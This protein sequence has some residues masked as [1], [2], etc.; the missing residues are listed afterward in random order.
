MFQSSFFGRGLTAR[1]LA[2][3]MLASAVAVPV[4][5]AGTISGE[6]ADASGTR[7]L[8]GAEVSLVELSQSAEVGQDGSY[9]FVNVPAGTYTLRVRY[10]GAE[11]QTRV[12]TVTE[13]STSVESFAL[14]A[15]GA[16]GDTAV[17]DTVLV[18]GQ[19]ANLLSSL[20]RQRASDTVDTVLTR[21]AIGQFPD[22]NVA[23]ALRR[24]PGI[25]VLNDQGEGRFV[26]V[27]GLDPN[28]NSASINGNRV[29][30]TGG[31][32]RAVALDVIPSELIESIEIKKSLTPDMD[33]DTIGGSVEINTTSAFDRKKDLFSISYEGSYNDLNGK[34][35]P[36]G[37]IDFIKLLGDRVGVSGG[38]SYYD[39]EFSTDNIEMDGWQEE[40]YAEDLEYRDYDVRRERYGFTLGL[41]L[42]ATDNTDLYVRGLYSSF[43][44]TEL[45]T[46][47]VF[48]LGEAS[49][50]SGDTATFDS[51]DEEITIERDLKD[52]REIQTVRTISA[53]GKTVEGPWTLTY[54]AAYSEADQTERGSIDPIIFRQDFEGDGLLGLTFDY[55]DL[56]NPLFNVNFGGAA[57]NDP[58]AYEFDALER[59][60]R[61][62]AKDKET[63]LKF[64][65]AREF[66]LTNGTLEIK[67]GAKLRQRDKSLNFVFD[68]Y[69]GYDGDLTLADV[70]GAPT[71]GLADIGAVPDLGRI[72]ALTAPANLGAFE[73]DA[74][75]SEFASTVESYEADE[76]I[77]AGYLMGKYQRGALRLIGGVRVEQTKTNTS[78]SRAEL[79]EEGSE[80]NGVTLDEDTLFITPVSFSN[81]YT[82]VL[83]SLN[84]R[85]DVTDKIVAR[86]GAFQSI[87]R[88]SFGK[89]APRFIIEQTDDGEREGEFGNPDLDPYRASNFD[90]T[91]EYY[92]SP[93]A[94][95]QGGVFYKKIDDYIVDVVF[96]EPGTFNGIAYNEAVIPLNGESAEVR[97]IELSYGQAFTMLPGPFDGLIANVNYTYTDTEAEVQTDDGLRSIPLPTSS[98]HTYNIVIGY[99]KGPVSLRLSGAGRSSYLDELGGDT[100]SDR[101]VKP[102]FQIDASAKYRF[103]ENFQLFA[104]L[105]NIN[106]ATYT[107]YQKGPGR[108]R[109]LQYEEYGWTAKLGFKANF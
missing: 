83:P 78:G 85:Y 45:R 2:S 97:G 86:F 73:L 67:S 49:S 88:P 40:G 56:E 92:F 37:A 64:D 47:L 9:R 4:A 72:R 20:A 41:D 99:D 63:A 7:T 23:E 100:E 44:D 107:A 25:N 84:I 87:I 102:H 3:S 103:I 27:R 38:F 96:D 14:A 74:L 16:G 77:L 35:S 21:D 59:T 81:D 36:K 62:D 52:R 66:A 17:M 105:V 30:A 60:T 12:I 80:F 19:Q 91:L 10:P 65:V 11:E 6:V 55:S 93:E 70:L 22:Q 58:S 108:E 15:R 89:F 101:Y 28:L 106:D 61:E 109:L 95:I 94:V 8:R 104:E 79:V 42:R 75:E 43:D 31:D 39:R 51:A 33:A 76:E 32:E 46:R 13:T 57:F 69:D 82:D 48:G 98:E 54:D 29:L 18:I 1:L 26:S 90:A 5:H 71:Y 24:A 34:T 68:I 50:V 53:G